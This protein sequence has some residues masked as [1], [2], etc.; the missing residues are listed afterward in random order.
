VPEG[1]SNRIRESFAREKKSLPP[2]ALDVQAER[3]LL[4]GRHYQKREIFGG[5]YL[6][7]LLRLSSEGQ[8]LVAYAPEDAAKKLPIF[9]K[10]RARIVGELH[11]SQDQYVLR[12][13]SIRVLALGTVTY[14]DRGTAGAKG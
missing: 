8:P 2:D 1:L 9:R 13:E 4:G 3:A 7:L 5:T 10:F 11:P 14:P 6:R 12:H